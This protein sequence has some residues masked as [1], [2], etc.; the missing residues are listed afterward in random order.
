MPTYRRRCRG[1]S[2]DGLWTWT[3]DGEIQPGQVHDNPLSRI[4]PRSAGGCGSLPL[5]PCTRVARGGRVPMLGNYHD[6][7]RAPGQEHP[8]MHPSAPVGARTAPQQ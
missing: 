3:G 1:Q 7:R 6:A 4:C 8:G 5:E 2:R